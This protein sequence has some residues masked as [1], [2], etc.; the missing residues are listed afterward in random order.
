MCIRDRRYADFSGNNKKLRYVSYYRPI[1]N[2]NYQNK[3]QNI[4][5]Q[6]ASIQKPS[7]VYS[8]VSK[9]NG[10]VY[11]G[12]EILHIPKNGQQKVDNGYN[13]FGNTGSAGRVKI[14]V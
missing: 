10:G 4:A 6:Y 3:F 5:G 2:N 12:Y 8:S 1:V 13:T 14:Q 11:Y 7:K 9:S